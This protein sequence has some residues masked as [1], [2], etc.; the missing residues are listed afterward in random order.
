MSHKYGPIKTLSF[1]MA[2][3]HNTRTK[4]KIQT[5]AILYK[6]GPV[7]TFFHKIQYHKTKRQN[8]KLIFDNPTQIVGF[9]LQGLQTAA[10][11]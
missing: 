10:F 6:R 9:H 4:G 2:S 1:Y 8:E 11:V 7:K 3:K 5:L